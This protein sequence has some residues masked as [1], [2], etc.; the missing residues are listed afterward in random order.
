[1]KSKTIPV[2]ILSITLIFSTTLI[3]ASFGLSKPKPNP[4][5]NPEWITFTD[6]LTGSQEVVGCCPNAGPCPEYTMTLSEKFEGL[7]G[8]YEGNIFMNFYGASKNRQAYI[9][10][11]WWT[12]GGSDYFF[13]IIGGI[14]ERDRKTKKLTVTFVNVDCEI[15]FDNS[16][17]IV[18][19]NFVLTRE[20]YN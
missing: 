18:Q 11:F 16:Y 12:K 19:V 5:T 17:L 15:E 7:Q 3:L 2:L 14:I 20:P 1:M 8:T 9:V 10:K 13:K 4:N 6:D